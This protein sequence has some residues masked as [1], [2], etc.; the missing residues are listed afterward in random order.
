M[1]QEEEG[2]VG[3]GNNSITATTTTIII[4]L[5]VI[6]TTQILMKFT[7]ADSIMTRGQ[8]MR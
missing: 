4:M 1:E 6:I 8:S 5:A 2:R 7:A 3:D